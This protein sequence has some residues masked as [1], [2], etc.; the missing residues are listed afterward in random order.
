M[1]LSENGDNRAILQ[2]ADE[3]AAMKGR[4]DLLED[5]SKASQLKYSS[6]ENGSIAVYD[7]AGLERLRL[8]LQPDGSFVADSK[9]N[10]DPPP[11]PRPPL[12]TAGKGTVKIQS[13]GSVLDDASWP[14]DFAYL[15][16]YSQVQNGLAQFVGTISND[17]GVFVLGPLDYV[18]V[19]VWFTAINTSGKESNASESAT[20]TPEKVVGD[21]L[22]AGTITSLQL[23]AQAV[24]SV[25]LAL[26]SVTEFAIADD[27]ITNDAIAA[28]SIDGEQIRANAITA[29]NILARTI[30][31][32][33]IQVDTILG[34]HIAA[35]TIDSSK[36]VA[37][38]ITAN[39]IAANA[40]TAAKLT[41]GAVTADKLEAILILATQII[42]GDP[43]GGRVAIGQTGIDAFN[44]GGDRVFQVK[45]NG[46]VRL[47]G[48]IETGLDG[49]IVRITPGDPTSLLQT[50]GMYLYAD[51]SNYP[52][53]VYATPN[54][55]A[56]GV[57]PSC[58]NMIASLDD[59]A[60]SG[61]VSLR[62]QGI[63]MGYDRLFLNP[64]TGLD[65]LRPVG[66]TMQIS[67]AQVDLRMVTV[68]GSVTADGGV[69]TL[70]RDGAAVGC[71]KGTNIGLLGWSSDGLMAMRGAWFADDIDPN[72]G[73]FV[74]D[75][76]LGGAFSS[77]NITY[78]ATMANWITR[79]IF[80]TMETPNFAEFCY[81]TSQSATNFVLTFSPNF[82]DNQSH[83]H[84]MSL[85]TR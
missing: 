37:L 71:V 1:D 14:K 74:D 44:L 67:E 57:K 61:H 79:T 52:A 47:T 50:P 23:A 2:L 54:G 7:A 45:N 42:A 40:I 73:I 29:F 72:N 38:S 15:K 53:L 24:Q 33:Q 16:I 59:T 25:H 12:L 36:L 80:G 41:A 76:P 39:E 9:N 21:D 27:A 31:G 60:G 85:Q 13:Q 10:P 48:I 20:V 84:F 4:V 5:G 68:D 18:P 70:T 43:T 56:L 81:L 6:I 19:E 83:V 30:T 62:D 26:D 51:N 64:L 82:T 28:H 3:L 69:L 34:E 49:S 63:Q 58:L 65:D 77:I 75:A 11:D 78:G 17:P 32:L 35:D 8:G 46:D 55:A 22:L 66:G